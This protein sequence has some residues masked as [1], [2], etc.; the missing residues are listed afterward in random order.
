MRGD[1]TRDTFFPLRH[2]TRVLQQQGRVQL[3]ADTNE[4]TAILLHFIRTLAADLIGPHG[5]P[6]DEDKLGFRVEADGKND[7]KLS[8]GHY[9]VDG[10]LCENEAEFNYTRQMDLPAA[11]ALDAPAGEKRNYLVYLDVWEQHI[12]GAQDPSIREPAL[13]GPDTTT[14]AR[15]VYQVRVTNTFP[16][17][18]GQDTAIVDPPPDGVDWETWL[19]HSTSSATRWS[20]FVKKRQSDQRGMLMARGQPDARSN[21]DL[22]LASPQAGFRGMENQL[23]RVEIHRCGSGWNA[24]EDGRASA[25]T[26]KWSRE[27][28]SITFPIYWLEDGAAE[29]ECPNDDRL[30]LKEWDWVEIS[31][32]VNELN[33]TA[34]VLAKV[35]AIE[36]AFDP[37]RLLVRLLPPEGTSLPAITNDDLKDHPLMRRWDHKPLRE[38]KKPED[39]PALLKGGEGALLVHED[40]WLDLESGVQICFNSAPDGES[41]DY[42]VGDYW[43]IPARTELED[44]LWPVA[45]GKPQSMPP[46]GIEHHYAPLAI[47]SVEQGAEATVVKSLQR[48][49]PRSAVPA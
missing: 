45:A 25:A 12:T 28:G 7:F 20:L 40:K 27:N 48:R 44:V 46:A 13:K 21:P 18:D 26:F 16:G 47:L 34:G 43:L 29:I 30:G 9:Y 1:F 14:R 36:L 15:L 8:K 19:Y 35:T 31:N 33:G 5:G 39:E 41:N 3:D 32:D 22:C 10:L 6:T 24:K 37:T 42:R 4:Q 23:Y 17:D 49:F 11:P 2:F 38:A